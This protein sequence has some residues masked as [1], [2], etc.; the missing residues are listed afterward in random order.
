MKKGINLM[1]GMC[2]R[3]FMKNSL[4]WKHGSLWIRKYNSVYAK[5]IHLSI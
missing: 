2:N 4:N 5:R 3:S 1:I